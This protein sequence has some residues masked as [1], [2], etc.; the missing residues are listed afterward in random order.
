MNKFLITLF[1]LTLLLAACSK[2]EP[3]ETPVEEP[4]VETP[5]EEA[6]TSDDIT[7]CSIATVK[8]DLE[9]SPMEGLHKE[10]ITECYAL[11]GTYYAFVMQPNSWNALQEVRNWEGEG[12]S[13][14]SGLIMKEPGENWEEFLKIPEEDFNPVAFFV[15][16]EDL[17]LD[18][19]DDSG[20][21]SGEG[22]LLR[23]VYPFAGVTEGLNTW[24][25]E[26]CDAYY[27]PE[28]YSADKTCQ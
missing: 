21:G 23:Y 15:R 11:D 26:K 28:T 10:Q 5:E 13:A 17:A 1:T 7:N 14:W 12:N 24:T 8:F 20:A 16:E 6:I 19:A 9:R 25:K 27:V 22:T 18:I 4:V 2:E 3:V